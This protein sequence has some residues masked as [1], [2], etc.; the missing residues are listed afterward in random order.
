MLDSVGA[1]RFLEPVQAASSHIL[2]FA[3]GAKLLAHSIIHSLVRQ[4][5]R[6]LLGRVHS[7]PRP[8][9]PKELS[10]WEF[11]EVCLCKQLSIADCAQILCIAHDATSAGLNK[12]HV[13]PKYSIHCLLT[14][15]M[16][17]PW[18]PSIV[19]F[20]TLHFPPSHFRSDN[21]L[22]RGDLGTVPQVCAYAK[23][24]R[25]PRRREDALVGGFPAWAD[26][27]FRDCQWGYLRQ[28]QQKSLKTYLCKLFI[29]NLC[30]NEF[31]LF[32]RICDFAFAGTSK[33]AEE[34]FQAIFRSLLQM[35]KISA[36]DLQD[37]L[38][39]VASRMLLGEKCGFAYC[40]R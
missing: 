19:S 36:Q 40:L 5:F 37:V 30:T 3:E 11:T 20:L 7:F 4:S 29:K 32:H 27:H 12:G 10:S 26:I 15:S 22:W 18:C 16:M 24:H 8:Q 17:P 9:I 21:V 31:V 1:E 33:A 34:T 2:S 6:T 14:K 28:A 25:F 38:T 13:I 23:V 35:P 39:S